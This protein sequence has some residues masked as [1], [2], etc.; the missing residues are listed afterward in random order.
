MDTKNVKQVISAA[1]KN[2]TLSVAGISVSLADFQSAESVDERIARLGKI[3]AD[4]E[5]AIAA[6]GELQA[7]ASTSKN[8]VDQLRK[9]IAALEQDKA[10]ADHQL[11]VS[12]ESFARLLFRATRKSRSSGSVTGIIIGLVTGYVSS[13]AVWLSTK[14]KDAKPAISAPAA[15]PTTNR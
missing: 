1:V 5:A 3:K 15:L 8:Q 14:D 7:D 9:E 6:V 10:T 12:E 11:K 4:L 13:Y 2:M